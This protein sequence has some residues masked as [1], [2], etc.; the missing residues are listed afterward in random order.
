MFDSNDNDDEDGV[1]NNEYDDVACC[2]C[3]CAVDF[4][5]SDFF[6]KPSNSGGN[7][8]D[9][10]KTPTGSIREGGDECTSRDGDAKSM[11]S[12]HK[13][14]DDGNNGKKHNILLPY[15]LYDPGNALILCD[16]P[17]HARA[18][19]R[20][21]NG[22]GK[23]NEEY[24]C[25]RA[26]H[27]RCHFVPVLS[28]PRGPWRCLICKYRDE[29]YMKKQAS[30]KVKARSS[31]NK[32]KEVTLSDSE[33]G[34]IFRCVPIRPSMSSREVKWSAINR[35]WMEVVSKSDE[36]S[37]PTAA[38][39]C[40]N[41]PDAESSLSST[42][43][44]IVTCNEESSRFTDISPDKA[45]NNY[46]IAKLERRFEAFSAHMKAHL[47]HAELTSRSRGII[48][49]SLATIRTAEHS[50]RSITETS[51]ARKALA[52]RIESQELGL[53]QELCQSV[54]RIAASKTRVREL[55]LNLEFVVRAIP[56]RH[57]VS[58]V[59]QLLNDHD[60]C[61][62]KE[63]DEMAR[64]I[65]D[66][67]TTY[68]C[69]PISEVMKWY[70]EQNWSGANANH[71]AN[72]IASA[73]ATATAA[74]KMQDLLLYLFPEGT[75][76]RRRHEPRTGEAHINTEARGGDDSSVTS[77]SLDDLVCW[78]C[79]GSHATDENDMLLCDGIGCYRSFHMKCLEPH[80]SFGDVH[81][82]TTGEEDDS[83]FC[84]LCTATA[85]LTH[86]AQIEYLG[87]DYWD[88]P[89]KRKGSDDNIN[90]E[91]GQ[92]MKEWETATEVF[93][94]ATFELR[95]AQKLKDNVRDEETTTFL[96]QT[97]GIF[98]GSSLK[99][100]NSETSNDNHVLLSEED[101]SDDD[102]DHEE[103]ELLDDES[104]A[105]DDDMERQLVK[106]KIGREELDALSVTS[107]D[108]SD[109]IGMDD[110]II[111]S[112]KH[113]P[114]RSKRKK[115]TFSNN[116]D[117]GDED[118]SSD[119]NSAVPPLNVGTVDTA[120]ILCGKRRRTQVDYRK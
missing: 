118:T 44:G 27:Q 60:S 45:N 8:E 24:R 109:S 115:L 82:N 103:I 26:Y 58:N 25:D 81:K 119:T 31:G 90:D 64:D 73:T 53:P 110:N 56:Q 40:K 99:D 34:A 23:S 10:G 50:L 117:N 52:E 70:L 102:F 78:N 41:I 51:K 106:E 87:D 38:E 89:K 93:P 80:L 32:S 67:N 21:N 54:M 83:W 4:S 47:L 39:G 96:A 68:G 65:N 9:D 104:F 79:H 84:P 36:E 111:D 35:D 11:R 98:T 77:I 7:A 1:S 28:I 63:E 43:A 55:I 100:E 75:L 94:E 3:K 61:T 85:N 95:V 91:G 97:L 86:F 107:T 74:A 49:S 62:I 16:G 71:E 18:G 116:V 114:R 57:D 6:V 76:K 113:R 22:K 17:A 120:N 29:E 14:D 66:G 59:I 105:E 69:D 12:N 46:N 20:G 42:I 92:K 30:R 72:V 37:L 2:L 5:E 101:E 112:T 108:G 88:S 33:L 48:K 13:K 15:R 19:K